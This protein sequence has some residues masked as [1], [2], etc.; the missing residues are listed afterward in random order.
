MK[1]NL[2]K[3]ASNEYDL[4][5]IGG[6]IYGSCVAWDA[7]LRGLSVALVEKGD[8]GHATSFN[9]LRII[10]GGFRY[11][12]S[13]AVLKAR[14]SFYEQMVFM[15]I[16]P[17][18]L[19]PLP[20]LVP[21]YRHLMQGKEALSFALKIYDKLVCRASHEEYQP[22]IPRGR[23]VT[24]EECLE[25]F[26][27]IETKG[28]T[29]G[30]IFYDCQI[31]NSERLIISIVKSAVEYG[32]DFANYVEVQGFLKTK[33]R[34]EG[35]KVKDL[36][37]GDEFTVR[38]RFIVNTAG[39]WLQ[40][41]LGLLERKD[42]QN[43]CR[44]LS[45]AFNLVVKRKFHNDFGLGIYCQ[46]QNH[47]TSQLLGKRSRYLFI[48]PWNNYSLIGT[49]HLPFEDNP[50]NLSI[51]EDEMTNFLR[52]INE[53]CPQASLGLE[54]VRFVY[55]GC[56][57]TIPTNRGS[58]HLASKYRIYDH[59]RDQGLERFLSVSGVKFTEARHVAE[60][61][62]DLVFSKL[63][64]KPLRSRTSV[65]PVYGGKLQ[66]FNE[67]LK[68]ETSRNLYKLDTID[69]ERL[70]SN[71]GSAYTEVLKYLE[72]GEESE[73][74]HSSDLIRKSEILHAIHEEM[75]QK[76]GDFVFRRT[77]L[78]IGDQINC[79]DITT[80]AKIMAQELNWSSGKIKEEV[81]EV[82]TV[83]SSLNLNG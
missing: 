26:P 16:A 78:D 66:W 46:A 62:V 57:P 64:K 19:H 71:Y 73:S 31:P 59:G 63:N 38:A 72:N 48:T 60:K 34:I 4:L 6:G 10:H 41:I 56:L 44:W 74:L 39:P 80:C 8:F 17:H 9:T 3:L 79:E 70:I 25:A 51:T 47:K 65:T 21:A 15:R 33:S 53:A 32:A 22:R 55:K 43:N 69:I 52:E 18:L 67:F 30:I 14:Q 45:K 1:R 75:A 37:T 68:Q 29:G 77:D 2:I 35:V 5:V 23:T 83:L 54:D 36:I 50:D 11:L 27:D 58:L 28:L 81:G 40:R 82:T 24:R 12:Q 49:E 61:V 7:S 13:L 42:F 20:V 76:L